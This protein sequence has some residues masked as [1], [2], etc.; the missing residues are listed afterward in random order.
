M[1][2]SSPLT[3][4]EIQELAETWYRKLDVHAP[5]NE[6]LALVAEEGLKMRFPEGTLKGREAFIEWYEG[7]IRVFFDEVHTVKE[8]TAGIQGVR[9][10]AK[11]VVNWQARRWKPPAAKSEWLGFDAYQTWAVERS[12]STGKPVIVTYIVDNLKPMEG[13]VAL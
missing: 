2:E 6:L 11:V 3:Q 8:V 7:V 5:V 13:S 9:A 1:N 10:E 4:N 12:A